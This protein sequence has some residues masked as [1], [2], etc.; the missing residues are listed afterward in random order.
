MRLVRLV[1]VALGLATFASGCDSSVSRADRALA[2]LEKS[3]QRAEPAW[4][5]Q[6]TDYYVPGAGVVAPGGGVSAWK[7]LADVVREHSHQRFEQ[8]GAEFLRD[9]KAFVER[10]NRGL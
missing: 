10:M 3:L 4:V 6:A 2:L 8:D 1:F 7:E 5:P 9:Y